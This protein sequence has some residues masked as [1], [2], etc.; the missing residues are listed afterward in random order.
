DADAKGVTVVAAAGNSGLSGSPLEYPASYGPVI[1]VTASTSAGLGT[2][3]AT[4]NSSVDL[5]AP[6]EGLA[7]LFAPTSPLYFEGLAGTSMAAPHVAAAA[8]LMLRFRPGLKPSQVKA[9]L[10]QSATDVAPPGWD[11][12]TGAGLLNAAAAV[13]LATKAPA[14]SLASSTVTVSAGT[15]LNVPFMVSGTDPITLTLAGGQNAGAVIVQKEG[16][17]WRLRGMATK[18]GVHGLKV[19]ATSAWGTDVLDVTL[20]VTQGP[21]A[22]VSVTADKDVT[23]A[24]EPV[25][26]TV[27][28][29]DAWGNRAAAP[30]AQVSWPAGMTGCGFGAGQDPPAR[31]CEITATFS[32]LTGRAVVEVFD[33]TRLVP[34]VVGTRHS[35]GTM[36]AVGPSWWPGTTTATRWRVDGYD[37]GTGAVFVPTT[38]GLVQA[39]ATM[40]YKQLSAPDLASTPVQVTAWPTVVSCWLPVAMARVGD[41]V[42]VAAQV[43]LTEGDG[44][45][46]GMLYAEVGGRQVGSAPS[47]RGVSIIV[48]EGLGV[49]SHQVSCRFVPANTWGWFTA[50][51]LASAGVLT[52]TRTATPPP[53]VT[54]QL[55]APKRVSGKGAVRVGQ[56]LKAPPVPSGWKMELVWWTQ[57]GKL[58]GADGIGPEYQLAGKQAGTL[59]AVRV[60]LTGPDGQ[61]TLWTSKALR[62]ARVKARLSGK[63]VGARKLRVTIK[64]PDVPK[65]LVAGKVRL[66]VGKTTMV[67]KAKPTR[68]GVAVATKQIPKHLLATMKS[69]RTPVRVT[70]LGNHATTKTTKT[71]KIQLPRS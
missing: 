6:G 58:I 27:W 12:I 52:I 32:G 66:R 16:T 19:T 9:I 70:W 26:A 59:V 15:D 53:T 34:V 62:V 10:R 54:A 29:V 57:D 38:L 18:A 42:E 68:T 4:H 28:Q 45:V 8:A 63:T 14:V 65:T 20:A 43:V 2:A 44:S 46:A 30:G 5:A 37:T 60:L 3:W 40:A 48:L 50:T 23:W 67:T 71:L 56:T 41:P 1:S 11:S 25:S 17:T 21:A 24:A 39:V 36:T 33:K 13:D 49:G 7:G 47:W 69:K 51:S 64:A 61:K 35:G 55:P 31:R 22:S